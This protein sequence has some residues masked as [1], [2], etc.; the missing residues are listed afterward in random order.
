MSQQDKNIAAVMTVAGS[1]LVL[2]ERPIP[3]PEPGEV[4]IRNHAIGINP[5]DWKRFHRGF[6]IR[7]SPTVLGADSVGLVVSVGSSVTEFKPGD[8][9]LG[10]SKGVLSG[11]NDQ[12]AYQTFTLINATATGIL[13]NKLSF[14]QGATLPTAV[15]TAALALFDRL[16]VPKPTIGDA[17][18]TTQ[19][20][21]I[22][23]WGGASGCGWIAIQMA[24]LAG[25]TVY[26]T[27]S[28]KHHDK[29][30]ALG[31]IAVVDYRSPTA[32]DDLVAAA[33]KAGKPIGYALDCIS[34]AESLAPATQ[35]LAK[36]SAKAEKKLA[37]LLPWPEDLP[38]PTTGIEAVG[39][40]GI[41]LWRE[42]EELAAWVYHDA[43][44]NWLQR[45]EMVPIQHRLIEG[46]L[47]GLQD[48][49]AELGKGASGERLV[50]E[51]E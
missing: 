23:I 10:L 3:S 48:G 43:L 15:G 39:V 44:P 9:V 28:A 49:L 34:L 47:G 32:V 40:Q 1:P 51:V 5:L 13:P 42:K 30:R 4:L 35:V 6:L 38:T 8:R 21:S 29:L 7:S 17:V 20:S 12:A 11:N 25:L 24:R 36:S 22:L 46:G 2:Q 19:S 27:A 16:G 37:H 45:G 31:V 33:E 50:V 14:V 41:D 26:T 18:T